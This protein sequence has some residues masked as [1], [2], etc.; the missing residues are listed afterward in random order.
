MKERWTPEMRRL[1]SRIAEE[2]RWL[3]K[4][5]DLLGRFKYPLPETLIRYVNKDE[6]RLAGL[7]TA[8]NLMYGKK[9]FS[10]VKITVN[11]NK[12]MQ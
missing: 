1:L 10:S 9:R 5:Q 12:E 2:E 3:E 11:S 7:K 6:A 8:F 4:R